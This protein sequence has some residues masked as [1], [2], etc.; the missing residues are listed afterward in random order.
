M[1]V[2]LRAVLAP[3]F[4]FF[5]LFFPIDTNNYT[6]SHLGNLFFKISDDTANLGLLHQDT[7][8]SLYFAVCLLLICVSEQAIFLNYFFFFFARTLQR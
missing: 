5:F 8:P 3:Q 2:N 1:Q 4:F 7:D 6:N